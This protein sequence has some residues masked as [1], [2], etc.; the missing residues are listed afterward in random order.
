MPKN[1]DFYIFM[2][3]TTS[4]LF[5]VK[6]YQTS[7]SGGIKKYYKDRTFIISSK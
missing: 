4:L 7:S 6:T 3:L 1:S 5:N 2:P